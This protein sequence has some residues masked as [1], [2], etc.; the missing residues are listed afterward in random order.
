MDSNY[1][2]I[3][4]KY[5]GIDLEKIMEFVVDD[6]VSSQTIT[7]TYGIPLSEDAQTTNI[8][9]IT[10]EVAESKD[11]VNENMSNIRFTLISNFLNLILIPISDGSGS[12]ILTDSLKNMHL[13]QVMA[14]NTLFEMGIIYE[15]EDND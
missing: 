14:F 2:E 7:Q 1:I 11:T 9:L 15:I 4:G 3:D 6:N 10:K 5:Y 8:K 12:L 13:G